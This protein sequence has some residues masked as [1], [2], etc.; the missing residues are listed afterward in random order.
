VAEGELSFSPPPAVEEPVSVAEEL[1]FS[2]PPAVEE[3]VSVAEGE[4]S[5]SQP[6][7]VEESV[8]VAA[9]ED[10]FSQPPAVEEPVPVAAVEEPAPVAEMEELVALLQPASVVAEEA[11]S[12]LEPSQES[13]SA[14]GELKPD[15]SRESRPWSEGLPIIPSPA[16]LQLWGQEP[17]GEKPPAA[18]YRELAYQLYLGGHFRDAAVALGQALQLEPEVGGNWMGEILEAWVELQESSGQ[19]DSALR[20]CRTWAELFPED[21]RAQQRLQALTPPPVAVAEEEIPCENLAQ[22][23]EALRLHP[24][25]ESLV[26]RTLKLGDG[27]DDEL[28]SVFRTLTRDHLDEP[29][30]FRNFA[31]VYLKLNKPM[32]AVVQYQKY[33]VVRPTA[34]GYKELAHAYTLLGREKNAAEAL[35]KAEDLSRA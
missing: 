11:V 30:H 15:I 24:G 17:E 9:G 7:A 6:P 10:S 12:A 16:Q 35:K 14:A 28:L 13:A 20:I 1:S 19:I 18:P 4:L 27:Q 34:D 22:A 29:L 26:Q 31:R 2:Q 5:F 25:N 33:L 21:N 32:L 3:S 8:P 23:L